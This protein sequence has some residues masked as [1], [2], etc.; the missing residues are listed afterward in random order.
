MIDPIDAALYTFF[1]CM[2]WFNYI[3]VYAVLYTVCCDLTM[4]VCVGSPFT[5]D[6]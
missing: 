2:S 6:E 4:F 5:N 1:Y 3:C